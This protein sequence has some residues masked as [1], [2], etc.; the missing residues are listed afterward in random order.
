MAH[1]PIASAANTLIEEGKAPMLDKPVSEVK[2]RSTY[3]SSFLKELSIGTTEL[4]FLC[5]FT[6][7]HYCWAAPTQLISKAYHLHGPFE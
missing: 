5:Q 3:S 6:H 4:P 2:L 1:A 7:S